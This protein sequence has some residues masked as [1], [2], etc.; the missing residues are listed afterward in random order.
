[1]VLA[2]LVIVMNNFS[3]VD[4]K[5]IWKAILLVLLFIGLYYQIIFFMVNDW[6]TN[7]DYSHGF[8]IPLISAYIIWTNR[9]KI[10]TI[11]IKPDNLGFLVLFI[12]LVLFLLGITGAEY[13]TMR[14]SM[15]PIILGIVYSLCGREMV[16]S[17]LLPVGFLVCMIPNQQLF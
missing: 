5:T 17:V 12:G 14:F 3:V 7:S 15:I 10:S 16:T 9:E 1:M 13:F 8:L 11:R 2:I 4:K 6:Y